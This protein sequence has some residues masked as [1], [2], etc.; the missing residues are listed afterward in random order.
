MRSLLSA[1][2]IAILCKNLRRGNINTQ[3]CVL[4]RASLDFCTATAQRICAISSSTDKNSNHSFAK[5]SAWW[6]ACGTLFL[7]FLRRGN[8]N[9]QVC[10][11]PRASFDFC[12]NAQRICAISS[13][14]DKNSNHSFAKLSAWWRA[15]RHAFSFVPVLRQH[16]HAS[17]RFECSLLCRSAIICARV[18]AHTRA[19]TLYT[20]IINLRCINVNTKFKIFVIFQHFT[21][22]KPSFYPHQ[23]YDVDTY[24]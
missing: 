15:Y 12:T 7:L 10:V 6:R 23:M 18:C 22:Q 16:Q 8:I 5:L 21:P 3:I 20:R 1:R 11:L 14:T 19:R 4:P 2:K 13:S 24:C 17:G 9:T